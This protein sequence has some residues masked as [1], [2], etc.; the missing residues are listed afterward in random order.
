MKDMWVILIL[1]E[2][3]MFFCS[4]EVQEHN[5]YFSGPVSCPPSPRP[6]HESLHYSIYQI[7]C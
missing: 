6:P 2:T 5:N 4:L 3:D 1:P 7:F